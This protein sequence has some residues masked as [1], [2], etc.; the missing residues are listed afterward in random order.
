MIP[1]LSTRL[2]EVPG[3]KERAVMSL[4]AFARLARELG[5]AA[6]SMR[7]SQLSIDTP[8]E[9]VIAA[10]ELLDGLGLRVSMVTGTVSLATNDARA[11]EPLRNITP[12]LDLA[13]RLGCDLIRVMI[14]TEADLPW[15]QRAADAAAERGI[16]LTHQTHVGTLVETV[17]EAL[18][19]VTRVGRPNFGLTYEP[20]NLLVCG[21][22]YGPQ[23]IRR[24][25]P[26]L[27]N[28]YLQ[29]WHQHPGGAM[30]AGTRRGTV[31]I[32]QIPLDDRRGIDLDLVFAGLREIGWQGY[33]TVH[34]MLLP[35]QD[36]A[37]EARRHR[38]AIRAA[39]HL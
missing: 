15:T 8:A 32:D 12:H 20:S 35:G 27:F 31:T 29:N 26:H 14:H 39:G 6:L 16:R 19:V 17:D 13:E 33:V 1:S 4:E 28:V 7:A 3:H 30:V 23:A 36:T 37:T 24:L 25:A 34:Q 11:T 2:A 18:E 5:Y 38:E 21:S 22:D 9:Q 10:R